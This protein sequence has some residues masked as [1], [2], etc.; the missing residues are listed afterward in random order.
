[1][2]RMTRLIEALSRFFG[3]A[4]FPTFALA[5]LLLYEGALISLALVPPADTGLGAFAADFRTWCLGVN[6]ATGR[7]DWAY[8]IGM[9]SPPVLAAG[10]VA[11][12]WGGTLATLRAQPSAM[13][14]PL[15]AALV[16]VA[17]G[18]ALFAAAAPGSAQGELPFPAE[19]LRTDYG[20]PALRLTDQTG[21]T[22]DM[23]ELRGK[24]VLLTGLYTS[25]TRTCPM[26]MAEAKQI[27]RELND[28]ERAGLRVVAVTLDPA[29][30]TTPVLAELAGAQGLAPPVW[31]FVTGDTAEVERTLDRMEIARTRDRATGQI[32]HANLFLLVDRRGRLAYRFALG[33]RQE[34]WLATAVRMLL[35]ES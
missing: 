15:L 35:H 8:A 7:T 9:I 22:V 12:L 5:V 23:T 33:R 34:R 30:D 6:P 31:H 32:D 21:A 20:P 19:A 24:V 28:E 10:V 26:I 13:V 1:M 11:W 16:V 3:G 2:T 17:G 25:C 4:A 18:G 29:H 27:V 14:R